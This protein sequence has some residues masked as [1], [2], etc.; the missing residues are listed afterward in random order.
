MLLRRLKYVPAGAY[1]PLEEPK[2]DVAHDKARRFL[3]GHGVVWITRYTDSPVGP[4]D[5]LMY[6]PG[7]FLTPSGG[8]AARMT[9]VYASTPA[10]VYNGRR[11]WNLPT[12]LARF[13]FTPQEGNRTLI[14]VFAHGSD[15]GPFF[16]AVARPQG[17]V[18]AL[19]CTSRWLGGGPLPHPPIPAGPDDRPEEAGT[20]EWTQVEHAVHGRAKIVWWEPVP[21][22][23]GSM[24]PHGEYA[25]GVGL[26]KID[27]RS[28]GVRWNPG[29]KV[30]FSAPR[31]VEGSN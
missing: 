23:P 14:E 24:I 6:Q 9:R 21:T 31:P 28:F 1:A 20:A 7:E 16:A 3:G 4:Y 22:R 25:D 29:T 12:H 13:A 27:I 8:S 18:P 10:A 19:P 5:E 26:P 2:D 15:A 17:V 30:E 11:N